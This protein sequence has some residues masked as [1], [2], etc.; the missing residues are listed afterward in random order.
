MFGVHNV[1]CTVPGIWPS[2][3][4]WSTLRRE[5]TN[6]HFHMRV[7]DTFGDST[8]ASLPHDLIVTRLMISAPHVLLILLCFTL[9][10]SPV[11][12]LWEAEYSGRIAAYDRRYCLPPSTLRGCTSFKYGCGTHTH[13]ST[14]FFRLNIMQVY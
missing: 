7:L 14:V 3:N 10:S 13:T 11:L 5:R 6:T 8:Y 4:I 1:L 2:A 12:T 9:L